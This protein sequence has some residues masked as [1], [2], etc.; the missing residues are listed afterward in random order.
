MN[1]KIFDNVDDLK[2]VKKFVEQLEE[3]LGDFDVIKRR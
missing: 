1:D 3:L 2:L